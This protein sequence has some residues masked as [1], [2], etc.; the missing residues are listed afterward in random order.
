MH[1]EYG[2]D[3]SNI[4]QIGDDVKSY[5][6]TNGIDDASAFAVSLCLDELFTNIATYGY[7]G[8]NSKKICLDLSVSESPRVLRVEVRDSAKPFNPLTDAKEPDLTSGVEGREIGGLGIFLIKK[9]MD[10]IDY[11]Y[12]NGQ[13]VLIMTKHIA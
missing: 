7:G 8:D 1:K 6:N 10:G 11:K 12:E 3:L 2:A 13:N 9:Y 5:C 4:D